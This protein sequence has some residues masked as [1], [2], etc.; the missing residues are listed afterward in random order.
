M[1]RFDVAVVGGGIVGAAVA[2]HATRLGARVVVFDKAPAVNAT[3]RSSGIVRVHQP[4]MG[5]AA[6]SY[7]GWLEYRH[8]SE[9][10]E[11]PSTFRPVGCVH[12]V[13]TA[14]EGAAADVEGLGSL[15][16]ACRMLTTADLRRRMPQVRWDDG[17]VA[18]HE[19]HAGYCDATACR[20]QYLANVAEVRRGVTVKEIAVDGGAVQGVITEEGGVA[21]GAVVL[22]TGAWGAE[23][24]LDGPSLPIRTRRIVW[25]AVSGDFQALPCYVREGADRLYF[26]P[27]PRRGMRFGV[28]CDDWDVDP[29]TAGDG[30]S[31]ELLSRGRKRIAR[32]IGNTPIQRTVIA[33]ADGYTPD[34]RPIIDQWPEAAGLFVAL[35]F[36]G[37]GFKTAPAVG[38]L[39]AQWAVNGRVDP[40]LVPFSLDRLL[41][42]AAGPAVRLEA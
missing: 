29:E 40:L 20:D 28:G 1:E 36:S 3:E 12:D 24:L 37:G 39:L 30:V 15:G 9:V 32:V 34:E 11:R 18:V 6:L 8:W 25:Q 38:S 31:A 33:A 22:A 7:M 4:D 23:E 42:P 13:S 17:I 14:P 19:L 16:W 5:L 21:A 35:G 2:F 26:R 27:N 41:T 10:V